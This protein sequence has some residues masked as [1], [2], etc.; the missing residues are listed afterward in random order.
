MTMNESERQ[1]W[2]SHY[3]H[4]Q[5]ALQSLP[6]LIDDPDG[7]REVWKEIDRHLAEMRRLSPPNVEPL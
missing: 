5:R 4:L 1:E 6:D 7:H 2:L 3:D